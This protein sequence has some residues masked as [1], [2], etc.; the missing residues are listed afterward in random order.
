[1]ENNDARNM[2]HGWSVPIVQHFIQSVMQANPTRMISIVGHSFGVT[3]ARDA[4]RRLQCAG[5]NPWPHIKTVV[6]A[7]GGNHG[8]L[9]YDYEYC[10][11][12]ASS[13]KGTVVC[14]MGSLLNYQPTAFTTP[15]NGPNGNYETPCI[16]GIHA[17]GITGACQGNTVK[18]HTLVIA[19]V[20]DGTN[21]DEFVSESSARLNGADN[22]TLTHDDID[23][24]GYFYAN[25][26]QAPALALLD[27]H[28]GPTRSAA[29]IAKILGWLSND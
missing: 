14:E 5:F 11:N 4:L 7:A 22:Q 27:G 26:V 16:D 3:T 21:V 9:T 29:G 25:I 2:D 13:M 1:M 18:W 10:T 12:F 15:L 24:S 20:P 17:F 8:V 6:G 28:F 19:D 23:T